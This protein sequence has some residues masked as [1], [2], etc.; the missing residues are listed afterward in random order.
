MLRHEFVYICICV[1]SHLW[2]MCPLHLPILTIRSSERYW[3][4]TVPR[5]QLGVSSSGT[6]LHRARIGDL[7]F[8]RGLLYQNTGP[9]VYSVHPSTSS[10]PVHLP[11]SQSWP[12]TLARAKTI[13][14]RLPRRSLGEPARAG[15]P[16]N[17]TN[18]PVRLE[19]AHTRKKTQ[20]N[21]Y[22][23]TVS[24]HLSILLSSC[25]SVCL[26]WCVYYLP[27]VPNHIFF[28][29]GLENNNYCRNPDNS[30]GPW[31]YTTDKRKRWEYCQVP[32]CDAGPKMGRFDHLNSR[33]LFYWLL[34]GNV[35]WGWITNPHL[36]VTH[37]TVSR[38]TVHEFSWMPM[39]PCL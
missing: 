10:C 9:C 19:N 11:S 28:V 20:P 5:E 34:S 36:S 39:S 31:C 22:L 13:G 6:L 24:S 29:S 30:K 17:L 35:C 3:A 2:K 38:E 37:C 14:E 16:R 15:R 18:T 7:L 8:A 1:Y 12:A 26:C 23:S 32:K 21:I 4:N 25:L 33:Q 27:T